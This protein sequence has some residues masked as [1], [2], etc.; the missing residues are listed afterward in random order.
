MAISICPEWRM[1]AL[2]HWFF[3]ERMASKRS[4]W[5]TELQIEAFDWLSKIALNWT[6]WLYLRGALR[7]KDVNLSCSCGIFA[8]FLFYR[9]SIVCKPTTLPPLFQSLTLLHS[10]SEHD[11]HIGPSLAEFLDPAETGW[12]FSMKTRTKGKNWRDKLRELRDLGWVLFHNL[13]KFAPLFF[14]YYFMP[15]S[16]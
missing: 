10:F 2:R 16:V 7:M 14:E 15:L 1:K 13:T 3:L 11:T 8:F 12:V 6:S 4:H 5:P 9:P